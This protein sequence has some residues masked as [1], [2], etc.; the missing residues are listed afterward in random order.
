MEYR[1]ALDQHRKTYKL[2]FPRKKSARYSLMDKEYTELRRQF[3]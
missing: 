3:A 2:K 1:A